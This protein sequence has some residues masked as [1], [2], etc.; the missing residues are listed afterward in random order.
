MA[1]QPIAGTGSGAPLSPEPHWTWLHSP[2]TVDISGDLAEEADKL[3]RAVHQRKKAEKLLREKEEAKEA[4]E[5]RWLKRQEEKQRFA[6]A[7]HLLWEEEKRQDHVTGMKMVYSRD[8]DF[9]DFKMREAKRSQHRQDEHD[10][11]VWMAR[12]EKS[13]REQ[14][15]RDEATWERDRINRRKMEEIAKRRRQRNRRSG[16][17]QAMHQMD[18]DAKAAVRDMRLAAT[19]R[20][21]QR[22][23]MW[24]TMGEEDWRKN[25]S[26]QAHGAAKEE[27]KHFYD[28]IS[29]QIFARNQVSSH[30]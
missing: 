20:L 23:E 28:S 14:Q 3:G 17:Q 21:V 11:W 30:A 27:S 15:E 4:E 18:E 10:L 25:Q 1:T 5:K 29:D 7:H 2:S 8:A 19:E 9:D 12:R 13:V 24:R 22:N 6:A 26:W 16:E